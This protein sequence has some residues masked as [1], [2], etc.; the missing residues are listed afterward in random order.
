MTAVDSFGIGE[1]KR[2][3]N[4]ILIK[5]LKLKVRWFN[6]DNRRQKDNDYNFSDYIKYFINVYWLMLF[7]VSVVDFI[8]RYWKTL[9]NSYFRYQNLCHY[10]NLTILLINIFLICFRCKNWRNYFYR[11]VFYNL[12]YTNTFRNSP[13]YFLK[14]RLSVSIFRMIFYTYMVN[15]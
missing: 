8:P 5:G 15:F 12:L 6:N 13:S 9:P 11:S 14:R 7:L 3:T 10:R 2:H 4:T 1:S